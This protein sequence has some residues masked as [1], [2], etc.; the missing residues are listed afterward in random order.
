MPNKKFLVMN[1]TGT[2]GNL[3]IYASESPVGNVGDL[4]AA[5]APTLQSTFLMP[6]NTYTVKRF[7]LQGFKF[8]HLKFRVPTDWF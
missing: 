4:G 8:M 5:K 1:N 7:Y 6:G 3:I 2:A